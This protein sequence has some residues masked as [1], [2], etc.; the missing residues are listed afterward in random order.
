MYML[1]Q[2]CVV[3]E[4]YVCAYLR[5]SAG[6]LVLGVVLLTLL[7]VHTMCVA[8]EQAEVAVTALQ[9]GCAQGRDKGDRV[10]VCVRVGSTQGR[11]AARTRVQPG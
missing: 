11:K 8:G 2:L 7:C 10:Q 6:V 1:S 5:A 9:P 4:C 3:L